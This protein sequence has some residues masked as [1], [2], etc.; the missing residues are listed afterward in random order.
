KFQREES[1]IKKQIEKLENEIEI[2][3]VKIAELEEFFSNPEL[4][5]DVGVSGNKQWEYN[6]NKNKLTGKLNEWTQLQ[7]KLEELT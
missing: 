6:Q 2:L 5:S 3:E 4:M 7:T 1:R